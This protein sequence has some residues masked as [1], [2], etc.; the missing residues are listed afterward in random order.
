M[1]LS[2][3]TQTLDDLG[4]LKKEPKFRTDMSSFYPGAPN[5]ALRLAAEGEINRLIDRLADGLPAKPKKSFVLANVKVALAAFN[6][7]DSEERDRVAIYIERIMEIT[8]VEESEE[9]LN[10]WRY[11]FPIGWFKKKT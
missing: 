3:S 1:N 6:S 5:E 8:G 11:G 2:V 10:V 7:A 4:A 9:L